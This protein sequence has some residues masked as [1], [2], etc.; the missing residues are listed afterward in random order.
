MQRENPCHLAND[1]IS[2]LKMKNCK[3]DSA[4][5]ISLA[6]VGPFF[7]QSNSFSRSVV[8]VRRTSLER[9]K[10]KRNKKTKS[11][12]RYSTYQPITISVSLKS[13][14]KCIENSWYIKSGEWWKSITEKR[15]IKRRTKV[16][17]IGLHLWINKICWT[18]S[19][20]RMLCHAFFGEN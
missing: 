12:Y 17:I 18:I 4:N 16:W 3:S 9:N 8:C 14:V 10:K 6:I 20:A 19:A 11:T 2:Y 7:C 5:A 1:R 13:V 15:K